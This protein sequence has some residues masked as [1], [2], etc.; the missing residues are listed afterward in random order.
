MRNALHEQLLKAGL[1]DERRLKEMEREQ[2]PNAG[3]Q[4]QRQPHHKNQAKKPPRAQPQA[5]PSRPVPAPQPSP[6]PGNE[7]QAAR[8]A[9]EREIVQLIK[10]GRLP[11]NDG[12]ELYNFVDGKKIGRIY[13]TPAT[14]A[15]LVRGELVVVR[16]R[17]RYAVV[18]TAT[19]ALIAERAPEF[20]I[21]ANPPEPL[22]NQDPAYQEF[23][24]PD[25]LRW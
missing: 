21:A 13:V 23:P 4:N 1:I 22:D 11:H 15:A 9:L 7:Q 2:R 5:Q 20:V 25:D 8:R 6:K 10:A 19:A 18:S 16:L 12:D 14:Q 17:S 3:G 24:V